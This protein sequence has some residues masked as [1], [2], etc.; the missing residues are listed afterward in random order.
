M[1][2]EWRC[3]VRAMIST[4]ASLIKR[5]LTWVNLGLICYNIGSL[6]VAIN[7]YTEAIALEPQNAELCH[8]IGIAYM[9]AGQIQDAVRSLGRALELQPDFEAARD[10]LQE[11]MFFGM[12]PPNQ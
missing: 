6:D 3:K 12:A 2:S 11:A 1:D 8:S 9:A 10:A 5:R 4:P 7:C